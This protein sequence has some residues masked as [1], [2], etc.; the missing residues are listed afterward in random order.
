MEEKY[1]KWL[2]VLELTSAI[3]LNNFISLSIFLRWLALELIAVHRSAHE[4]QFLDDCWMRCRLDH[5]DRIRSPIHETALCIS[6]ANK[7]LLP[8]TLS[9]DWMNG[10]HYSW[11]RLRRARTTSR[12]SSSRKDSSRGDEEYSQSISIEKSPQKSVN[13]GLIENKRKGRNVCL[14]VLRDSPW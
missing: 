10:L 13:N 4:R 14:L 11:K 9:A 5:A 2:I 8:I 3:S 6:K 1:R 7:R 12:L